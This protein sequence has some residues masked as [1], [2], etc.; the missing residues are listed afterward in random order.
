MLTDPPVNSTLLSRL[1]SEIHRLTD[2]QTEALRMATFVG[3]TEDEAHEFE[4]RRKQI[5]ELVN[6]CKLL[7]T[8]RTV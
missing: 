2:Q 7:M 8:K 5:A 4:H 3:M 6:E 1:A